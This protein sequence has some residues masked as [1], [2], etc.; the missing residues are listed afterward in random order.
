MIKQ[1]SLIA[2]AL[3][4]IS[5]MISG[6]TQ[7][8]GYSTGTRAAGGEVI[9]GHTLPPE[10]DPAINN[11]TLAGVDVNDNGV[12]DDVERKIYLEHELE[13]ER[14]YLMMVAKQAIK[15][16]CA[17]DLIENAKQWERL[18]N[19][20]DGCKSYIF[21]EYGIN[22]YGNVDFIEDNIYNTRARIEKYMKYNQALSGGVYW[23]PRSY[24]VESSCDFNVTRAIM[25]DDKNDE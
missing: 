23:T 9:N 12:R 22:L 21:D 20:G 2:I 1:N 18:D 4:V 16:L 5:I 3:L 14:Q 6:C 25:I 19:Y 24:E 17:S 13:I 11:A 15:A 7:S 8:S 10:P